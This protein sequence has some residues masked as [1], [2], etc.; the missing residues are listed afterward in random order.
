MPPESVSHALTVSVTDVDEPPDAPQAP[1]FNSRA[2]AS[3]TVDWVAPDSAGR[4]AISGYDLQYHIAGSTDAYSA[5]PVDVVGT[6]TTVTGLAEGTSYEI[7][8]R[9]GNDEGESDWS[10]S[11]TDVTDP[12]VSVVPPSGAETVTEGSSADFTVSRTGATTAALAVTLSISEDGDYIDGNVPSPRSF[13]IIADRSSFGF[14]INTVDDA[15]DEP[16]GSITITILAG[17]GYTV[18]TSTTQATV[19]VEDND[20]PDPANNAP[21]ITTTSPVSAAEN[22]TAVATLTATDADTGDDITWSKNGGADA[23]LFNLTSAGVLS[24]KVEP[25]YESPSDADTDNDYVV[26][27]QA[28]DATETTSLTLTVNVTDVAGPAVPGNFAITARNREAVLDWDQP[29]SGADIKR[30]EYRVRIGTGTD[31]PENWV[32]IPTSARGQKNDDEYKV[33][34]LTNDSLYHF[35][36]RAVPDTS[37]SDISPMAEAMVTPTAPANTNLDMEELPTISA[38]STAVYEIEFIPRWSDQVSDI[39]PLTAH[40]SRLIGAVH[41]SELK[42]LEDGGTASAGVE[43]MAEFGE[44]N[45]LKAE[46]NAAGENRIGVLEGAL[47]TIDPQYQTD[48]FESVT[49]TTEHPRITLLTMIAP[50]PGLVR[51]RCRSDLAGR[52]WK[53][54]RLTR[55]QSLPL[56]CGYGGWLSLCIRQRSHQSARRHTQHSE[57]EKIH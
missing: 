49:V 15:T 42:L 7:Q 43:S 55:N 28:S 3:I 10:A 57:R 53:L 40:F 32:S 30:H 12:I 48:T 1:T 25:D 36:L 4:P 14:Q 21:V 54:A 16:D 52:G 22:Q 13:T 31:Y 44:V 9:A 24:F 18:D 33:V 20:E 35:Q 37:G 38:S 56:G 26:V 29:A 47:V 17:T 8:V 23:A 11:L 2:N 51:G 19:T 50:S 5:G 41:N 6:T 34:R 27:V 39:I 45:T 46:I